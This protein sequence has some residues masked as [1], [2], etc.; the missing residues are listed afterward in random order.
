[1]SYCISIAI[2]FLYAFPDPVGGGAAGDRA[3]INSGSGESSGVC[4]YLYTYRECSCGEVHPDCAS[5]NQIRQAHITIY[6]YMHALRTNTG[7]SRIW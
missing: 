3:G 7:Y 2:A 5:K 1:M 4:I 6:T